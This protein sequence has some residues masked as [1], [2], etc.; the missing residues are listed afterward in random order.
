M[1]FSHLVRSPDRSLEITR[2]AFTTCSLRVVF[3]RRLR[4]EKLPF[5]AGPQA[6]RVRSTPRRYSQFL[7]AGSGQHA[8][9]KSF[10]KVD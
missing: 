10:E 5:G 6:D 8:K 4:S 3:S 2:Q 9:I 7:L 1:T